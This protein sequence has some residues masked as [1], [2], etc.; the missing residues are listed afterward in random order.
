MI[1]LW[2]FPVANACGNTMLMKP[3]EKDPGAA[4]I[5][6]RLAQQ[7]GLP[8]GVLQLVH[9]GV[10]TVNF[11]CDAPSVRAISFVGGNP[12]GEHIFARGTAN[13]KRVQ[14]NL[15]AKNHATVMPDAD[16]EATVNALVGAGF[17]AAGQR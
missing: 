3:S 12:A 13:G 10:D 4:M 11:L 17:G 1:P 5:I 9:G 6:A 15:G 16:R 14:A 8:D 7:A 2:M